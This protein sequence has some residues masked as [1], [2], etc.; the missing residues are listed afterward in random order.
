LNRVD[1][2]CIGFGHPQ[3][4]VGVSFSPSADFGTDYCYAYQNVLYRSF[5]MQ[6][7]LPGVVGKGLTSEKSS[8]L[9]H[10][11]VFVVDKLLFVFVYYTEIGSAG[12]R[13]IFV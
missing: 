6:T 5:F 3:R 7:A 4:Q 13:G 10:I 1:L 2:L 8:Q 11:S 12:S 9:I